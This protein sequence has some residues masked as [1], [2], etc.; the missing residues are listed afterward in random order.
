MVVGEDRVFQAFGEVRLVENHAAAVTACT[1]R[2]VEGFVGAGEERVGILPGGG[3]GEADADGKRKPGARHREG[4]YRLLDPGGDVECVGAGGMREDE[5]KFIATEAADEI[6]NAQMAGDGRDNV[7]E[8]GVASGMSGMVVDSFEVVDVDEGDREILTTAAGTPELGVE[9]LLNAAAIE[10]ARE[11]ISFGLVFDQGEEL[12]AEHEQ[13]R[14]TDEEG[15]GDAEQDGDDLED[16]S[17]HMVWRGAVHEREDNAVQSEDGVA[18]HEGGEDL[19]KD[20]VRCL[21]KDFDCNEAA[22]EEEADGDDIDEGLGVVVRK[23]EVGSEGGC[24]DGKSP[25]ITDF[26]RALKKAKDAGIE[27]DE[28]GEQESVRDRNR[29][30]DR[31]GIRQQQEDIGDGCRKE[32]KSDG[33][34]AAQIGIEPPHAEEDDPIDQRQNNLTAEE[35]ADIDR[36]NPRHSS[37]L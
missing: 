32:S 35:S 2:T 1:F 28:C 33:A 6:V 24:E 5:E 20:A 18:S 23:D 3:L 37:T 19:Q 27:E 30:E 16:I 7:A 12:T 10:D 22:N 26:P 15:T 31:N 4:T 36:L 34:C 8:G 14:E 29:D 13:E 21:D 25:G 9:L 17:L 11:Q